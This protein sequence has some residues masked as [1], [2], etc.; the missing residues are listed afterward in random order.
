VS[1]HVC[2]ILRCTVRVSDRLLMCG[3]H[4]RLVPAELQRAVYAAYGYGPTLGAGL[5]TPGLALAQAD[6][7]RAVNAT[8]GLSEAS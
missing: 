7:I 3:P 1:E 2:P 4:W 8:L 6:A 5:G